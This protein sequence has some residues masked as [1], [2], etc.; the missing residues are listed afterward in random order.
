MEKLN[1]DAGPENLPG[2]KGSAAAQPFARRAI[3]AP[4]L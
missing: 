1:N 3:P 4:L 2:V